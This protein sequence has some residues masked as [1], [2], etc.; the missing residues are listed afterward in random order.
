MLSTPDAY[1]IVQ[2]LFQ[3]FLTLCIAQYAL[4]S[5]AGRRCHRLD[6]LIRIFIRRRFISA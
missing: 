4:V 6:H 1:A 3:T 5:M 2:N